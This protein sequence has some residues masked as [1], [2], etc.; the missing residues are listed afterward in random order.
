MRF[1]AT[2][3]LLFF[4][5]CASGVVA[6]G[7][8]DDTELSVDNGRFVIRDD[9]LGLGVENPIYR[10][11]VV[12]GSVGVSGNMIF[13]HP[14]GG[15]AEFRF[16]DYSETES[17]T[18]FTIRGG[19]PHST[20]LGTLG[21]MAIENGSLLSDSAVY[22]SATGNLGLEGDQTFLGK[23]EFSDSAQGHAENNA[24][25]LTNVLSAHWHEPVYQD[26]AKIRYILQPNSVSSENT[27]MIIEV[28][29]YYDD[30]QGVTTRSWD[31]SIQFIAGSPTVSPVVMQIRQGVVEALEVDYQSDRRLKTMIQPVQ[32]A[33][34][35]LLALTGV[36]YFFDFGEV[37]FA[38]PQERQ[39]GFVAQDV[40]PVLPELVSQGET[41]YVL[42]YTGVI[43]VLIEGIKEHE[44]TIAEIRRR[45]DAL[46][47]QK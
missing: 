21:L 32:D 26:Y 43:P 44:S 30:E 22:I 7:Y 18:G 27:K 14:T 24:D 20:P 33:R 12:T 40:A 3:L 39:L 6:E 16:Y 13:S 46:E 47:E 37:N 23:Y 4:I 31:D 25:G 9:N 2:F 11:Q 41:H 1:Y 5:F 28:G 17:A 35:K 38:Y 42:S 19:Q 36:K 34:Q 45:L 29:N 8:L 15:T 10:L